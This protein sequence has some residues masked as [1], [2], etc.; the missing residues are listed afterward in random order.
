MVSTV[1]NTD[2]RQK[3][4]DHA[5]VLAV[6]SHAVFESGPKGGD[7]G[8][9]GRSVAFPLLQALQEVNKRLLEENPAES[10]LFDVVLI[11]TESQQQQQSSCIISSTRHHGLEVSRFC[12]SSEED[13]IENLQKNNVQLFL[14]TNR[15]EVLQARQKGVLSALLDENSASSP[16]DQLRVLFCGDAVSRPDVGPTSASGQAAQTFLAQLGKIRQKF[17]MFDSPV[18][19]TLV[20]SHGGRESCGDALKALRSLGVGVDEAYCLAGA[21]C[22][23]ILS[24][25]RHHFLLSDRFS[26]LKD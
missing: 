19:I 13:F 25:L 24:L 16:T 8:F 5:V 7:D 14:S 10:L 17:R 23:P 2:V 3:D 15:S 21:P 22:G 26:S 18:C 9:Y 6:T 1:E 11:T 12:F 20:T 4:A